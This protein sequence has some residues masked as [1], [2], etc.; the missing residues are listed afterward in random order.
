MSGNSI[1]SGGT[2]I[3]FAAESGTLI[4][5][6]ELNGGGT[7]TKTT[8][9]TLEMGNGNTY[10]GNTVVSGGTLL[11]NNT[12]GSATGTGTVTV[13]SGG[14]LGGSGSISGD[15]TIQSGGTLTGG[16]N[17]TVDSLDFGGNLTMNSGSTW[18]VDLAGATADQILLSLNT[19]TLDL[20][21]ATLA[22]NTLD[23]AW[24][25]GQVWTIA[26]FFPGQ[27]SGTFFN[28]NDGDTLFAS[29][30]GGQFQVNYNNSLGTVTLTAVPEPSTVIT[31]ILLLA[32]GA[33]IGR[34]R[35]LRTRTVQAAGPGER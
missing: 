16:T 19:A 23:T 26:S 29:G 32:L 17:G 21:T 9:G 3:N 12:S 30:S 11:A 6:G 13:A 4:N 18:L 33:W 14:T 28:L 1:G 22:V 31:L 8:A 35:W 34:K 2:N 27:L 5:L 7:F 25:L 20:G 24:T 10:T 15:T